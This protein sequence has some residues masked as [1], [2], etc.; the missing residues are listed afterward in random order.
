MGGT[1]ILIFSRGNGAWEFYRETLSG[2]K[3][4]PISSVT[5]WVRMNPPQWVMWSNFPAQAGSSWSTLQLSHI[6]PKSQHLAGDINKPPCSK[7]TMVVFHIA[8]STGIWTLPELQTNKRNAFNSQ[9]FLFTGIVYCAV[10]NLSAH[11]GTSWEAELVL[12]LLHWALVNCANNLDQHCRISPSWKLPWEQHDGI[13]ENWI[14]SSDC[15][16]RQFL[17]RGVLEKAQWKESW[18]LQWAFPSSY[19]GSIT[20]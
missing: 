8:I 15:S 18:W 10:D 13:L 6:P 7:W 16:I 4:E 11:T 2:L 1:H 19:N 3:N 20:I 5:G 17:R 9:P 12:E 14:I